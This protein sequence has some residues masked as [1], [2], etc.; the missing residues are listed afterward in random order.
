M[1]VGCG[2]PG[3]VTVRD[4]AVD[5][6]THRPS[7]RNLGQG[8]S[9][10]VRTSKYSGDSCID[11]ERMRK[12]ADRNEDMLQVAKVTMIESHVSGDHLE[13]SLPP[14]VA[15]RQFVSSISRSS[16]M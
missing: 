1:N 4:Q 11:Q 9:D 6:C 14:S 7:D 8:Q 15:V 12:V 5:V 3:G 10:I 13:L 2:C 16:R